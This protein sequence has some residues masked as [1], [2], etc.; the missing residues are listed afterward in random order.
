LGGGNTEGAV[1]VAP[2]P[3]VAKTLMRWGN[4][5]TA[6]GAARFEPSEVPSG[7][8][9][10]ANA[11]PATRTLPAS[12]YLAAKPSWWPAS[13]AWPPVGPDVTGGNIAGLNGHA[14][15]IPAEDCYHHA[16]G[17]PAD[18]SGNVLT[19]SASSCYGAP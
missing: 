8:G 15:T 16:M 19:F 1:T 2:D 13:K 12:F 10:Y 6:N 11:V 14:N 3:L 5:D 18:G 4:Y 17:G 9:K 7:I